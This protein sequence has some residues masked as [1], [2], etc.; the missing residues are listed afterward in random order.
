MCDFFHSACRFLRQTRDCRR[1]DDNEKWSRTHPRHERLCKRLQFDQLVACLVGACA[2]GWFFLG[3]VIDW[4]NLGQNGIQRFGGPLSVEDV[5][6]L[7]RS[8][9]SCDP[10]PVSL[11]RDFDEGIWNLC[12]E[13]E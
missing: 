6:D 9:A 5:C 2:A 10:S 7:P 11:G 3:D 4:A 1:T 13:R 8:A 12:P